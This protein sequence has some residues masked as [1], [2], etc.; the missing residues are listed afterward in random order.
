M[1]P[2][3]PTAV[4]PRSPFVLVIRFA[5]L[6]LALVTFAALVL[7]IVM[8][9]QGGPSSLA[10]FGVESLLASWPTAVAL[11]I[12]V[13]GP[14]VSVRLATPPYLGLSFL[15]VWILSAG[16]YLL[17]EVSM[18]SVRGGIATLIWTATPLLPVFTVR[19]ILGLRSPL[20]SS[21]QIA[22]ATV[23]GLVFWWLTAPVALVATCALTG[24]CP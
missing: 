22:V 19:T 23:T 20:R 2:R 16:A 17:S 5:G 7:T 3:Q 21:V 9:V 13:V 18:W 10:E 14:A 24:N 8:L 6:A 4:V 1:D 15:A 12:L 11:A